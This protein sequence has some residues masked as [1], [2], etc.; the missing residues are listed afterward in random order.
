MIWIVLPLMKQ[1]DDHNDV[2]A[3]KTSDFPNHLRV[4]RIWIII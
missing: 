2:N 1:Y 4:R 3:D